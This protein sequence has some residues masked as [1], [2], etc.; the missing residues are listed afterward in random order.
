MTIFLVG[1]PELK[2]RIKSLRQLDQRI[3]IKYHLEPFNYEDTAS[4]ISFRLNKAGRK[5]NIFS[6]DALKK[7]YEHSKGVPRNV[8]NLCDLSL[9]LG[10]SQSENSINSTIVESVINDGALL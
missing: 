6:T 10:Y 5:D 8:N 7:I 3:P 2:D 9:L 1:Q 4:Y